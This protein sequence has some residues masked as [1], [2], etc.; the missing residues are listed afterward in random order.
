MEIEKLRHQQ[1]CKASEKRGYPRFDLIT[2]NKL[3]AGKYHEIDEDDDQL[4]AP[5][6]SQNRI[7][8]K[9]QK[10]LLEFEAQARDIIF[11]LEDEKDIVI[12]EIPIEIRHEFSLPK[13]MDFYEVNFSEI[14]KNDA[15][16]KRN[17]P[18]WSG[19][20]VLPD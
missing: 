2:A 14:R 15:S 19:Q 6:Y 9:N 8:D 18:M 1:N 7:E 3:L 13:K 11:D 12:D 10:Q 20:D 5:I 4:A 16:R 17:R